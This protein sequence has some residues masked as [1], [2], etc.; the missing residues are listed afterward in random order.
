MRSAA[1]SNV[2]KVR[3]AISSSF[4][5]GPYR[6]LILLCIVATSG[7]NTEYLMTITLIPV[8]ERFSNTSDHSGLI[9]FYTG[10]KVDTCDCLSLKTNQRS[11]KP[12]GKDCRL[13]A[14][15]SFSQ[16]RVRTGFSLPATA[17][18]T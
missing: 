3:Y 13:R 17:S 4:A 11:V 1:P 6:L 10:R 2:M 18:L 5:H 12:C 7:D 14:T 8:K 16:R 15:K 9:C